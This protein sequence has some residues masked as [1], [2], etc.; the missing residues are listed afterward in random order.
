MIAPQVDVTGPVRGS[1]I[2]GAD[3]VHAASLQFDTPNGE[4]PTDATQPERK[5]VVKRSFDDNGQTVAPSSW[6]FTTKVDEGGANVLCAIAVAPIVPYRLYEATYRGGRTAVAGLS[7]AA[8]RDFASYLKGAG[9]ALPFGKTPLKRVIGFGYSQ[10]AHFLRSFLR[11]GCNAGLD[12]RIAFDGMMIS[13]AG[14]GGGS[15]NQRYAMPG[16][17]GT[18]V[19]SDL[20]AVDM[21][22]FTDN[23]EIDPVTGGHGGLLDKARRNGSVPKMVTTLSSTEY[24]ARFASLTYTTVDGTAELPIDANARLYFIAGT[25]HG[26]AP[27]PPTKIVRGEEFLHYGNFGSAGPALR[28]LLVDL[29]DWIADGTPPP[30]SAYPHL[31]GLVS[32]AALRFPT[33]PETPAP[34]YAPRTWRMDF[35]PRFASLGIADNEPPTLGAT[36]TSLVPQVD[37][38]GNDLGGLALPFVAVPLGTYTGWNIDEEPLQSFDYLSGLIGSFVPFVRSE[39]ERLASNDSRSSIEECYASRQAYLDRTI[40]AARALVQRRFIL[41]RDVRSQVT[42]AA[43][44]WDTLEKP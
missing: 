23:D 28:A 25:P 4:C 22:P 15:F 30:P 1:V 40:A 43:Q 7:Y 3:D 38:N 2:T 29:D 36:Y 44:Q 42:L 6:R 31:K 27:F 26:R 39:K 13:S 21:F 37:A 10:S 8:L 16:E 9:N 33:I 5:L 14:A 12:G 34:T 19:L 35:G 17:A 41:E 11:D 20:R 24:W 18:S 32:V